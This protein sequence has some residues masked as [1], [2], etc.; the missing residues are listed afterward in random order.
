MGWLVPQPARAQII[1]P[2]LGLEPPVR[3]TSPANHAV[4]ESPVDIPIFAYTRSEVRF[5]NVEFYANGID[6]GHGVSLASTNRIFPPFVSPVTMQPAI[7]SRLGTLWCFVWTNAGPPTNY[8]LTAVAKGGYGFSPLDPAGISISRTSAPVNITILATTNSTVP[9][10][11]VSVIATDPIAIAGTNTYWVW[12]GMTNPVPV[13]TNWPPPHW[14]YFT[15]W[16]PKAAL[17]T[18]RRFGDAS[19]SVTVDY[20]IGGTASN[21]VDYVALPGNVTISAGSAYALIPLVPI[22]HGSNQPVKTVILTLTPSANTSPDY[23][24]GFPPCAEAVIF[25]KWIRPTPWLLAD[26]G[27]HVSAAGPD[28]AWFALQNSI[29]LVNWTTICT[30]QIF[31]GSV[32]F[33]DPNPAGNA[34]GYYRVQALPNGP[35]P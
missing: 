31:Q 23:G 33:I 24:I 3:I 16:G 5:T 22:D 35:S 18:V 13:W 25:Y 27:F 2:L 11:I 20:K 15:N 4:F 28:G 12:A 9:T 6:L 26:G 7:L 17:F 21:G 8:A 19:L 29:D 1:D 34:S 32:D 10:N 14:G 30:N